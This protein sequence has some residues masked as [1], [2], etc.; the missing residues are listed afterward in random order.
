MD[1]LEDS[2]DPDGTALNAAPCYENMFL[3]DLI[4]YAT[5]NNFAV[6]SGWVFLGRTSTKQGLM[7]NIILHSQT[8]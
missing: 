4:I 5:V 7:Q 3:I 1:T 2:V 6:M 8:Q